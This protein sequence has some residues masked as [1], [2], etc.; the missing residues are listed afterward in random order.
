MKLLTVAQWRQLGIVFLYS[1]GIFFILST[2]RYVQSVDFYQPRSV[3]WLSDFHAREYTLIAP[4]VDLAV[5]PVN[6]V[7]T[8]A[9]VPVA[10][11]P[12]TRIISFRTDKLPAAY[13]RR[14]I[15]V[16]VNNTRVLD[17]TDTGRT[18]EYGVIVP[19]TVFIQFY[20]SV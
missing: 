13:R 14:L 17:V 4:S 6:T 11:D 3:F 15:A 12:R 8:N 7:E 16:F 2:I 19:P 20:H 18:T 5:T 1:L 10:I 9:L